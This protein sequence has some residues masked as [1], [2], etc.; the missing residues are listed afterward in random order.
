MLFSTVSDSTRLPS[1]LKLSDLDTLEV[2]GIVFKRRINDGFNIQVFTP[3]NGESLCPS[4]NP[5]DL[6]ILNTIKFNIAPNKSQ[7]RG[8]KIVSLQEAIQ[9]KIKGSIQCVSDELSQLIA[10]LSHL[11]TRIFDAERVEVNLFS[12]KP[13]GRPENYPGEGIHYDNRRNRI[14][15]AFGPGM[16]WVKKEEINPEA[17]KIQSK[18]RD[19]DSMFLTKTPEYYHVNSGEIVIF[20]GTNVPHR[21]PFCDQQRAVLII[22]RSS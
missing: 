8:F 14:Y 20:D 22:D 17:L 4:F 19:P 10:D 12:T 16:E 13:Q 5:Q 1:S 9:R 18:G 15:V 21:T 2:L 6:G 3:Q 7:W 11:Y